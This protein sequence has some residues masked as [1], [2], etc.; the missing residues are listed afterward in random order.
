MIFQIYRIKLALWSKY[1]PLLGY[2]E[3]INFGGFLA[4]LFFPLFLKKRPLTSLGLARALSLYGKMKGKF[5]C[6]N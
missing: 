3:V 6:Q 1:F 2:T 5:E 4:D